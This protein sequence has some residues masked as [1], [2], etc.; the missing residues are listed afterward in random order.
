M[1]M[2]IQHEYHTTALMYFREKT[3]FQVPLYPIDAC[4]IIR[5]RFRILI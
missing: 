2:F 3:S 4:K 1:K 5:F